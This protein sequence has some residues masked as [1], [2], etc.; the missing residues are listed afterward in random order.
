MSVAAAVAIVETASMTTSV[1]CVRSA[2]SRG[3]GVGSE[4]P[5]E[6]ENET[7]PPGSGPATVV[8]RPLVGRVVGRIAIDV[9]VVT[10]P[11]V[12]SSPGLP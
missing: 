7:P 9:F 4:S 8:T 2:S 10:R 12:L 6:E 1:V 11:L 5:G 3:A